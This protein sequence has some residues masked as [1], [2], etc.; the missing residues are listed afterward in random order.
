M[1][2]IPLIIE[3]SLKDYI[4]DLAH[5]YRLERVILFGSFAQGTFHQDSDL[6]LAIFSPDV[7]AENEISIMADLMIRA[8]PYKL[9][10]QPLVFPLAD[11]YDTTNDFI[12][13][14][15]IGRGLE[16][17]VKHSNV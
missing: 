8:M 16:I 1:A 7:T 3:Q 10:I 9:D 17:N 14:E 13:K 12:Q 11:F 4:S 5:S 2:Q 6:D 15:I